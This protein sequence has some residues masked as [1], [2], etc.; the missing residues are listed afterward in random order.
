MFIWRR[1]E[2]KHIDRFGFT[3]AAWKR[4]PKIPGESSFI[5]REGS[6]FFLFYKGPWKA[7][8]ANPSQLPLKT[9]SSP[10]VHPGQYYAAPLLRSP[11]RGVGLQNTESIS[12]SSRIK[13]F[14]L[15]E[16][17]IYSY[18]FDIR[19]VTLICLLLGFSVWWFIAS[20]IM[21]INPKALSFSDLKSVSTILSDTFTGK[22]CTIHH[23]PSPCDCGEPNQSIV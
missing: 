2:H 8:A 3:R 1:R 10:L 12:I 15:K 22:I 11:Q 19:F 18:M 23:L 6:S 20:D 14:G 13:E 16:G 17:L 5:H 4:A 21:I 7:Y 9:F